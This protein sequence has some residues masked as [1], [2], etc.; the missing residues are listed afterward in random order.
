MLRPRLYFCILTHACLCVE[1]RVFALIMPLYV[2]ACDV[3]HLVVH[4]SFE[5]AVKFHYQLLPQAQLALCVM[6]QFVITLALLGKL[7]K[8]RAEDMFIMEPCGLHRVESKLDPLRSARGSVNDPYD[9]HVC[10]CTRRLLGAEIASLP[11][12]H[13]YKM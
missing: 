6:P 1:E 8:T 13:K 11:H 2:P 10:S 5:S 4:C 9:S 3:L 12:H 7:D